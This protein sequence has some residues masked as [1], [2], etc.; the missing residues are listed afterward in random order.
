MLTPHKKSAADGHRHRCR[1]GFGQVRSRGSARRGGPDRRCCFSSRRRHTRYW[2]DWSSDVCS[3]DLLM[4]TSVLTFTTTTTGLTHGVELLLQPLRPLRV[5]AHEFAMILAIALRFVP[6]LA[7][8]LERIMKAQVS[9][10]AD[11]GRRSRLRFLQQARQLV[12]I[13]VP[14]FVGTFR[15]AEDLVLAMEARC[16][17]GGQGRTR[18]AQLRMQRLDWI[19][20]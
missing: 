19:A 16:Y 6:T 17:V 2:R 10:G 11:F 1:P 20:L 3:S 18:L 7:E 4:V 9:R 13:V 8:E 12:P 14:L 5:P 15:R